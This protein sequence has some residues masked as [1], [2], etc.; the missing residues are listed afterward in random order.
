MKLSS[1]PPNAFGENKIIPYGAIYG[2]IALFIML[3]V[4]FLEFTNLLNRFTNHYQ[5]IFKQTTK[6]PCLTCGGTRTVINLAHFRIVDAFL[7]N[8][9]VCLGILVLLLWGIITILG[10]IFK[11]PVYKLEISYR[12]KKV[13]LFSGIILLLIHWSYLIIDKR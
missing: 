8:P 2:S 11:S 3:A 7:M 12:E 5:C 6:L 13:I 9:L 1:V 10:L 4:Y